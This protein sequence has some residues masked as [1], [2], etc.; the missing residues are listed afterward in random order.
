[1]V[2]ARS[3]PR[4]GA[5]LWLGLF[6]LLGILGLALV[7][8]ERTAPGPIASVHARIGELEG[9]QS[10]NLCHGGWTRSMTSA[11]LECHAPIGAQIEE[12]VGLHGV[13]VGAAAERCATCHAEH[14]GDLFPLVSP[15]SFQLAGVPDPKAFDHGPIGWVMQGKHLEQE[16]SACHEHADTPILPEGAKR[17]LGISQACADCHEDPHGGRHGQACADCHVQTGFDSP[18]FIDHDRHLELIGGHQGLSCATCHPEGEGEHSLAALRAPGYHGAGRSCADCHASPHRAEFRLGTAALLGQPERQ[19]CGACHLA[20]HTAWE[21]AAQTLS[22]EAH[23]SSGFALDG[24]H[25]QLACAHC[26]ADPNQPVRVERQGRAEGWAGLDLA[27]LA[28]RRGTP[29]PSLPRSAPKAF[30]AAPDFAPYGQRFPG[31]SADGCAGCHADPHAGQFDRP[32]D[33]SSEPA[34]GRRACLDCHARES[35]AAP[36]FGLAEHA[37]TGL[38][39]EGRHGELACGVC[40]PSATPGAVDA[41]SAPLRPGTHPPGPPQALAARPELASADVPVWLAGIDARC[42]ACHAD[43]HRGFF[44][45]FEAQLGAHP[46]GSCAACHSAASFAEVEG[47]A[48]DHARHGGLPLDGAHGEAGC[49][50]CHPPRPAPDAT[51]R[52]FGRV[53]EDFGR[54]AGCQTCHQDPHGGAFADWT[55]APGALPAGTDCGTCHSTASFRH[56]AADFDHGRATG[57]ALTGAHAQ[58][59]CSACHAP[60]RFSERAARLRPGPSDP[61][62]ALGLLPE[63]DGRRRAATPARSS[64]AARG[65]ACDDCHVDAHGGQ[66]A[67]DGRTDC[68]ACHDSTSEWTAG[69]FDHDRD[70]RFPLEGAHAEAACAACHKAEPALA[71]LQT[72]LPAPPP[73][74]AAPGFDPARYKPLGTLC[75]DCHAIEPGRLRRGG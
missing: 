61:L 24:P 53:A 75:T 9:G 51:G 6:S 14:H 33:G 47:G 40:H 74:S 12:R 48:F 44:A 34:S 46:N 35:F 49:S 69:A 43:A 26:H 57:Y 3:G 13:L 7:G 5:Q 68:G 32:R 67:A 21:Q 10:C 15:A 64:A 29:P 19:A 23:G 17:F 65:S 58:A 50:V 42:S 38:P 37:R 4:L 2:S 27:A 63:S 54:Y 36:A 16:C 56:G 45:G 8:L 62:S 30:E 41:A 55:S 1:M 39:L 60:A 28:R 52:T 18:R 66:F 72:Q 22:A 59:A 20:E 71:E 70:A 25:A 73:G 11:C 31:R